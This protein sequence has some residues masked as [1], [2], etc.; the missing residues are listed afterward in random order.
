MPVL[1][2]VASQI[3]GHLFAP[4]GAYDSIASASG[5]GASDT[6]TFSSI[7]ATYTH[8]QI[9]YIGNA[10]GSDRLFMRFNGDTASSYNAHNVIGDGSGT[11]TNYSATSSISWA[12][13]FMDTT[14]SATAMGVG[15]I[16][17][18]DY[19]NTNK[20]KTTRTLTGWDNNG[21]G[22]VGLASGLWRNT[23]AI[24]SITLFPQNNPN[25]AT[26][27]RFALYGIRG[28]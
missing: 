26:N 18:L 23:S 24:T 25:W 2:I 1:G 15:V 3:S 13:Y 6:I 19:A 17:I 4:S 11:G 20:Y 10:S 9:R 8:L 27:T 28:N 16:D 5:T 12:G 7:P 21:S 14:L 22:V